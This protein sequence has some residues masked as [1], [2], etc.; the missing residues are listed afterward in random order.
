MIELLE[1]KVYEGEEVV[2]VNVSGNS[3]SCGNC[4]LFT[5]AACNLLLGPCSRARRVDGKDII[6]LRTDD[7]LKA[8]LRGSI[9]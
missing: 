9:T 1:T 3:G 2:A 4:V 5:V 8:R 7:A 6:W